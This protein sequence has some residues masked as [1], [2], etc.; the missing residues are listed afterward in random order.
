MKKLTALLLCLLILC[1]TVTA[2][3][4]NVASFLHF[5]EISGGT[6]LLY[7]KELPPQG[8]LTVSIDSQQIPGATYSTIAEAGTPVTVYCLVDTST[9]MSLSQV[10]QQKDVLKTISSRMG[11]QD[12][13]VIATLGSHVT[14]GSPLTSKE[15]R[16]VA[17]DTIAREGYTTDLYQAVVDSL[18]ALETRTT[19][20]PNRFLLILSDGINDGKSSMTELQVIDA[21][22][23]S[24]VPVYGVGI[25]SPYPGYYALEH[26]NHVV[27]MGTES[28][29]GLGT[30]PSNENITAANAA[31]TIWNSIRNSTV[32][33]IDL[34]RVDSRSNNA[35][36]HVKYEA[37]DTKYEDSTTVD[38]S[39]SSIPAPAS[40]AT[41]ATAEPTEEPTEEAKKSSAGLFLGVGAVLVLI[42]VGVV[43]LLT[44]KKKTAASEEAWIPVPETAPSGDVGIT[45][46]VGA[47]IP[48]AVPSTVPAVNKEVKPQVSPIQA[49]SYDVSV[50]LVAVMHKDVTC[51]FGL[52]THVARTLGRD[53]RSEVVVNAQDSSLSGKHCTMEWDGKLLYCQ[54]TGST[55][56][57]ALNGVPMKVGTWYPVENGSL[58]RLG[59]TEYRINVAPKK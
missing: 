8:T 27:R 20:S 39:G 4:V 23:E 59:G 9:S 3:A 5:H 17:I 11:P 31:E 50:R 1:C 12:S 19:Y 2:G 43:I 33:K 18:A 44:R 14:E 40:Q 49:V 57:S 26:A 34:S 30:I 37:V 55:N 36:V 25:V 24:T 35:T 16:E 38:L 45:G 6:L 15:A 48:A 54:D 13:M 7:G 42:V 41:A 51:S 58:I 29:G 32:F 10:Q 56:G 52:K 47:T 46:N 53:Q 21:I 22:H 28:V